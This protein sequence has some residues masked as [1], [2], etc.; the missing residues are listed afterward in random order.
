MTSKRAER[1]AKG[2]CTDC[3]HRTP[4]RHSKR[5]YVCAGLSRG[6]SEKHRK[7]KEAGFSA[8]E[9]P[10]TGKAARE[11]ARIAALG[12]CKCGLFL[13]CHHERLEDVAGARQ[14]VGIAWA[15]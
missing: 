14:Y 8:L 6:Y 7:L 1:A 3:G 12:R 4:A 10:E 9:A 11:S 15:L 13:P 2:L 5:C